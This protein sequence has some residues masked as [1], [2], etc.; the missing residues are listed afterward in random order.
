MFS[1]L[2][3][4][5]GLVF[6]NI[7]SSSPPS[8][9]LELAPFE[10]YRLPLLVIGI[11]DGRQALQDGYDEMAKTHNGG[12]SQI[13]LASQSLEM[14]KEDHPLAMVHRIIVFDGTE[15]LAAALEGIISVPP[16]AKSRTT[17][18]KTVMCDMT[19]AL[20][21]EMTSYAKSIQERNSIETPREASSFVAN[22]TASAIPPH[23]AGSSR[24]V[25]FGPGSRSSSP[26]VD[27]RL[28]H[29]MS[30]PA[31]VSSMVESRSSTP[32]GRVMSP[33]PGRRTPPS[34][35]EQPNENSQTTSP[36]RNSSREGARPGSQERISTN[37][38]VPGSVSERERNR[39]KARVGVIVG[40][41]YLLA[42]RW[43]DALKE[44]S[45]S[46]A[47]A[48]A[49]SDYVWQAKAMD[50]L[51]VCLLMSAWAGMDFRVG[52]PFATMHSCAIEVNA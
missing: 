19:S 28:G 49:N 21:G 3:F 17:T 29:R 2:A 48:R 23:M 39:G 9:H 31:H 12:G 18:M 27:A 52:V 42:G 51:L 36:P 33:P 40:A 10:L 30:M 24:P 13:E 43:P 7:S 34:K 35:L 32:D 46:A 44:L 15:T 5:D 26:T 25:S 20:L 6:Y 37:G 38:F 11:L 22:V 41:L 8:S 4:P 45:N 47:T 1:P 50:Y 16:P 14:I